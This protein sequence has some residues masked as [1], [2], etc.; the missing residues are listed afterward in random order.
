[1]DRASQGDPWWVPDLQHLAWTVPGERTLPHDPQ[2]R[3]LHWWVCTCGQ[4]PVAQTPRNGQ[5]SLCAQF[6]DTDLQKLHQV[7]GCPAQW[8]WP[9][10]AAPGVC[11]PRPMTLTPGKC[12]VWVCAVPNDPDPRKLHQVSVSC[13][14]KLHQVN[15]CPGH[16]HFSNLR[17]LLWVRAWR[18]PNAPAPWSWPQE[19]APGSVCTA[20]DPDFIKLHQGVCALPHDPDFKKKRLHQVS[21]YTDPWP[22]LQKT[23]PGECVSCPMIQTSENCTR[24]VPCFWFIE[25]VPG[26]NIVIHGTLEVFYQHVL[27]LDLNMAKFSCCCYRSNVGLSICISVTA[28]QPL[29]NLTTVLWCSGWKHSQ[30]QL[31]G[32]QPEGDSGGLKRINN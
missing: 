20:H 7:G 24:C 5:M 21:V 30:T 32:G 23:A 8:P 3:K 17:K 2:C 16:P 1:M 26:E 19:T 12:S 22:W 28:V 14:K 15:L 27:S 31:L 6:N 18:Y 10:E 11:V 29:H 13:T 4:R 9:Q 25:T